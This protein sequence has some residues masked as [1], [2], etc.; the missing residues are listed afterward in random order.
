MAVHLKHWKILALKKAP[1]SST[2]LLNCPCL[3]LHWESVFNSAS[4]NLILKLFLHLISSLGSREARF[5]DSKT[6]HSV[7]RLLWV[8]RH[9]TAKGEKH[10]EHKH[11]FFNGDMPVLSFQGLWRGGWGMV[12]S[13]GH[14]HPIQ[15][16]Q[17]TYMTCHWEISIH[18]LST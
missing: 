18:C 2:T 6:H 13:L 4:W 7:T 14:G 9:T 8:S 15:L 3:F 11:L 1:L 12:I 17:W 16:G 5:K 10:T